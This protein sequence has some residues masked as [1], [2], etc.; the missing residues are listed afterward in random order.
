M[1]V[2]MV[3]E[4]RLGSLMFY[5]EQYYKGVPLPTGLLL[6]LAGTKRRAWAISGAILPDVL[7]LSPE[8]ARLKSL[9]IVAMWMQEA[10]STAAM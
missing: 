2:C 6:A 9:G 5:E 4:Y 10:R 7:A 1:P 8:R 3:D